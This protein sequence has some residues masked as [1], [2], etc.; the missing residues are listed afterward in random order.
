MSEEYVL[1]SGKITLFAGETQT[2]DGVEIDMIQAV[3]KNG[4]SSSLPLTEA[5]RFELRLTDAIYN[6]KPVEL[7][8]KNK[9]TY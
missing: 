6:G 1:E 2:E 4:F 9:F 7:G 3:S 5:V 8:I